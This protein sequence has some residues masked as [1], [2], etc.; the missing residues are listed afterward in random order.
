MAVN[1]IHPKEAT[2]RLTQFD[3]IIDVRSPAE[4]ADDHIPGA[5]NWPV[6]DDEERR[7][8]G[9]CYVQVSPFEARKIGAA[10]VAR[11]IAAHI[12]R[13]VASQPKGWKPLVYCWRGGER[14]GTMSWFLDRIGFRARI[15]QGG[16]K[17]YRAQVRA[18]LDALPL[19]LQF[20]VICGR[21][22]SGKTRLLGA[23]R[24]AGAQVLDLEGLAAHRGSL[25]G[26][27]PG[28]AQPS[29]KA[30]ESALWQALRGYAAD[31]P[32]FVE[33]ESRMIGRLRVPEV[34]LRRMREESACLH[35]QVPT[36]ARLALL[37]ED[38]AHL[39]QDVDR[40]CAI[41]DQLVELRSRAVV[42]RWQAAARAGDLP[43]VFG[44]LMELHYD[45][46]YLASLEREFRGFASAR[47]LDVP[48][49]DA[50]SLAA[51]ARE[52]AGSI[53]VATTA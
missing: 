26:A 9:T 18:N 10:M 19:A 32:V 1:P 8:V 4:F 52:L 34:L 12:D 17:A 42:E 14:S 23:L 35:L 40:F 30:F 31:R 45:P 5:V 2:E 53:N 25:L 22:G 13:H 39:G 11:N 49:L 47:V 43:T 27:L 50:A 46:G 15:L 48:A 41:L 37:L 21:T 28:Q 36:A 38:Y 24:E 29:Q 7:I 6:L 51:L 44:E 16:Y 3:T 20:Q 33:S